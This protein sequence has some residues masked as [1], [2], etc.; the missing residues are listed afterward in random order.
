MLD[1]RIFYFTSAATIKQL[2]EEILKEKS[3]KG[4]KNYVSEDGTK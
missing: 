2:L 4:R 3:T 1:D